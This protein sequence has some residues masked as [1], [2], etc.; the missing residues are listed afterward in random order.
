MAREVARRKRRSLEQLESRAMLHGTAQLPDLTPWADEHLGLMY[1]WTVETRSDGRALLLLSTATAN[2]GAGPLELRGG[3]A[4]ENGTQD[5]FQRIELSD[6]THEERLAGE[7]EYHPEHDHVHFA[8]FAEYNLREITANQGVGDVVATGGKTSFCVLD[9]LDYDLTLPGAPDARVF[10]SCD[11]TQGLSVGWADIYDRELPDQWIDV[12]GV[13]DGEYWLEVV[14]DP[15]N[16]LL[17]G[18]ESN[19]AVRILIDLQAPEPPQPD[20]YEPNNS[21]ATATQ[22]GVGSALVEHLSIHAAGDDDWYAWTATSSGSVDVQVQFRHGDGDVDLFAYDAEGRMLGLSQGVEDWEKVTLAL[23]AGQTI[24]VQVIGF[25]GAVNAD[26]TLSINAG[27]TLVLPDAREPN[28]NFAAAAHLDPLVQSLGELNLH[29]AGDE[30]FFRWTSPAGGRLSLQASF[31]HDPSHVEL[32]I[33]DM[34]HT[35]IGESSS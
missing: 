2:V 11:T 23:T 4:H 12:T 20:A 22:F 3:A 28:N 33:Y 24:F 18:D 31:D 1:D 35:L 30:D 9:L 7:F 16:R 6:G 8:G 34:L 5:V 32:S 15:E 17:E 10:D 27:G 25:A 19:N 21:R 14:V 29:S 13:S 26:Y